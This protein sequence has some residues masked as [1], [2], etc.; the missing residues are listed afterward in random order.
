MSTTTRDEIL[1]GEQRAVDHA[2]DCDPMKLAE[3][4]SGL[5]AA[6]SASGKDVIAD[7]AEA[8]ARSEAYGG[9]DDKSPHLSW[10]T[11]YGHLNEPQDLPLPQENQDHEA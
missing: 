11:V 6:A 10:P 7:Q 9:L 1:I 5:T 4:I 8:E 2:Y 3:L